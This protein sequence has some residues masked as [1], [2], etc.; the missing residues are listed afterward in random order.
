[1]VVDLKHLDSGKTREIKL[2]QAMPPAYPLTDLVM[3]VKTTFEA[4]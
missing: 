2:A 1:M 3:P 4:V